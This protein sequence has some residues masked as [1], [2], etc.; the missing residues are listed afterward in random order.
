ME[1]GATTRVDDIAEVGA[2]LDEEN[3]R[4]RPAEPWEREYDR[5]APG[6]RAPAVTQTGCG[7]A[8]RPWS[9]PAT[10][11]RPAPGHRPLELQALP[12]RRAVV[13]EARAHRRLGQWPPAVTARDFDEGFTGVVLTLD[14]GAHF[15]RRAPGPRTA[16]RTYLSALLRTP[17]ARA[18]LAQVVLASVVL[19]VLGLALRALTAVVVDDVVPLRR[20]RHLA[21]LAVGA[22]IPARGPVRRHCPPFGPTR[23]PAAAA[24]RSAPARVLEH[25]LALPFGFSSQRGSGDLL[26][27]LGSNAMIRELLTGG[28]LSPSWTGR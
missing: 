25:L 1:N 21:V 9:S 8:V 26:L 28:T 18:L 11:R 12:P 5:A 2:E 7:A 24:R 15:E 17:G 10:A 4:P 14:P 13:A 19:Q 23:P 20:T 3:L 16:W 27:R 6:P 22:V